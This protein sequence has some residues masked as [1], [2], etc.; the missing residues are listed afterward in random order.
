MVYAR[1]S[2]NHVPNTNR[3]GFEPFLPFTQGKQKARS[4]TVL[5]VHAFVTGFEVAVFIACF[6]QISV[7]KQ[8]KWELFHG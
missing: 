4:G 1:Q 7:N 5:K 3:A 2:T 8:P 6:R